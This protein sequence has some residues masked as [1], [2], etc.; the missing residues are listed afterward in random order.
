MIDNNYNNIITSFIITVITYV[1]PMVIVRMNGP[2]SKK[3]AHNF[4]L[5]NSI[6]VALIFIIIKMGNGVSIG[7]FSPALLYYF[8]NKTILNSGF[9]GEE[10]LS[11]KGAGVFTLKDS[12]GSEGSNNKNDI[13]LKK[14]YQSLDINIK[15]IVFKSGLGDFISTFQSMQYLL[16]SEY[17]RMELINIY[18]D[19][20]MSL[21]NNE[22]N[23]VISLIQSQYVSKD[24]SEKASILTSFVVNHKKNNSLN[25]I[26]NEIHSTTEVSL[27]KNILNKDN[28]HLQTK[29][30]NYEPHTEIKKLEQNEITYKVCTKCNYK[31]STNSKFCS[32]CGSKLLIKPFCKN[33][34][35][36]MT[37]NANFC[38]ACGAKI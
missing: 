32:N 34:G 19:V 31:N 22:P 9:K 21:E 37:D 6:I 30:E 2:L 14:I 7:S 20:W 18:V 38:N 25:F 4:A 17:S 3:K 27:E 12:N 26:S 29:P 8:I 35:S 36:K 1:L 23:E 24:I 28:N 11:T 5:G 13:E 16:G 33:C 10:P 15:K